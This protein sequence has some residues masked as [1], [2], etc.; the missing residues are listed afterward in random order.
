MIKKILLISTILLS[1]CSTL[2]TKNHLFIN[3]QV[4]SF[5]ELSKEVPYSHDPYFLFTQRFSS[6]KAYKETCKNINKDDIKK[7]NYLESYYIQSIDAQYNLN[8]DE[9]FKEIFNEVTIGL[10]GYYKKEFTEK[11]CIDFQK[12]I[13]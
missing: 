5:Q 1:G 11:K 9:D 6:G 3:G 2:S 13:G 12:T 10:I 8:A 4:I 7:L